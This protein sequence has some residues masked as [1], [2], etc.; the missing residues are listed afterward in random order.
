MGLIVGGIRERY[1]EINYAK[2]WCGFPKSEATKGPF[3]TWRDQIKAYIMALSWKTGP[4][5]SDQLESV[6]ILARSLS[7]VRG[8]IA[9]I[10]N[11]HHAEDIAEV[12]R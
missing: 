9:C 6:I 12:D 4:L 1:G 8:Q 7:P 11:K 5:T 10:K 2:S 3:K